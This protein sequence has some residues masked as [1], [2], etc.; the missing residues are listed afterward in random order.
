MDIASDSI[1]TRLIATGTLDASKFTLGILDSIHVG[2]VRRLSEWNFQ[3]FSSGVLGA[4]IMIVRTLGTV[5]W[6]LPI[7][8]MDR[9]GATIFG[10]TR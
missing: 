1:V 8:R 5:V 9:F 10:I 6:M 7:L 4:N 3:P 2:S